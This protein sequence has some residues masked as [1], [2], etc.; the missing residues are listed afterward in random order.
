MTFNFLIQVNWRFWG[1]CAMSPIPCCIGCGYGPC[2]QD[3]RHVRKPGTNEFRG[4]LPTIVHF[5]GKLLVSP[6]PC[7]P[8]VTPPTPKHTHTPPKWQLRERPIQTNK[9]TVHKPPFLANSTFPAHSYQP[10]IAQLACANSF[11]PS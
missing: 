10:P 6:P 8:L 9:Q 7:H 5:N 1:C 2:A 3:G 11:W 4:K